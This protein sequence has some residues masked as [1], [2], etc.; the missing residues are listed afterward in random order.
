MGELTQLL[1]PFV[2]TDRVLGFGPELVVLGLR[3]V[4]LLWMRSGIAEVGLVDVAVLL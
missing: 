2:R 1:M 4:L 3:A